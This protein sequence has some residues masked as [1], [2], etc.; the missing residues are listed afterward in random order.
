[1]IQSTSGIPRVILETHPLYLWAK[2]DPQTFLQ[3]IGELYRQAYGIEMIASENMPTE[4]VLA[5][6]SSVANNKYAEG[7]VGKSK[8]Y[9][10][11]CEFVDGMEE[12]SIRRA[13]T[14]FSAKH[15][16][17]QPHSGTQA[18]QAVYLALM[19]PGEKILS[20][21]LEHGGHLSHGSKVNAV[22]TFYKIVQYELNPEGRMDYDRIRDMAKR[23]KPK[24]IVVGGS[25]YPRTIDFGIC[26]GIA[27]ETN[28]YL[29][30]DIAHIAG[31]I[32]AGLH[33]S[34]IDHAH[35]TTTTTHK[36]LRGPRGGMILLGHDYDMIIGHTEDGKPIK[37]YQAIDKAVF[38]GNQGGPLE[39][40]IAAKAIAFKEALNST[41][42]EVGAD[43]INYQKATLDNARFL[44]KLLIEKGYELSSGGTENHL[45]LVKRPRGLT[46][47]AAQYAT[48]LIGIAT[49]KNTVPYDKE[50][51]FVTSGL[52]IGTPAIT[53]RGIGEKGITLIV[54]SLDELFGATNEDSKYM[55]SVPESVANRLKFGIDELC[56]EHLL[57]PG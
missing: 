9:Y 30:S 5:A 37:L 33:P 1:M 21:K 23:E 53:T 20:L 49:N 35:A 3:N 56:R 44:A 46:G 54:D 50:S 31:L 34:S 32:A 45:V 19:N 28:S 17:V 11:G 12:A 18:N 16:N 10:G 42:T 41:E 57:Y 29:V 48:E 26:R 13:K 27:D 8:R 4:A 39:H 52:R 40:V 24:V 6:L 38:P 22:C 47:K 43:F 7:N 2:S 36:T 55:P 15:A 25:A 51:P 14:L